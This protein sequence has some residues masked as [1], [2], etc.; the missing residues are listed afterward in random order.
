MD[1]LKVK[2]RDDDL[3]LH[4]TSQFHLT[5]ITIYVDGALRKQM[6]N[7]VSSERKVQPSSS[8]KPQQQTAN[9]ISRPQLHFHVKQQSSNVPNSMKPR[10]DIVG[11]KRLCIAILRKMN[12]SAT[13]AELPDIDLNAGSDI[14]SRLVLPPKAMQF[15]TA[16]I[17][18]T[19]G[20]KDVSL[21]EGSQISNG[22]L[23]AIQRIV[24]LV[25]RSKGVTFNSVAPQDAIVAASP[26][27]LPLPQTN[28][29]AAMIN[30]LNITFAL[31]ACTTRLFLR[32]YRFI[33]CILLASPHSDPFVRPHPVSAPIHDHHHQVTQGTRTID[34]STIEMKIWDG[35]YTTFSKFESDILLIKHNAQALHENQND[36]PQHA[37]QLFALFRKIVTC[38]KWQAM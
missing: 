26:T 29:P 33:L 16:M 12:I 6:L 22:D 7:N 32:L 38:L 17:L 8:S 3:G 24:T 13:I 25:M 30:L 14:D 27:M 9:Y 21:T 35:V 23:V 20:D 10:L 28:P 4:M 15:I 36:I 19:S 11:I 1:S 5:C 18:G 2:V 34:L 37:E 31:P